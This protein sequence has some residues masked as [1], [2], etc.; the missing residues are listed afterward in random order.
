L[1]KHADVLPD[2]TYQ[3][4]FKSSSKR[5]GA[6]LGSL[7]TGRV[8]ICSLTIGLLIKCLTIAVRYA[9]VR[10]QFGPEPGQEIPI[11]EYQTHVNIKFSFCSTTNEDNPF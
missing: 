9:A 5:F 8:G 4:P 6:S 10:K 11:I 1:N 2:G 3:T 7:S